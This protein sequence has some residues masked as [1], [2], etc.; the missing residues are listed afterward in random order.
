MTPAAPVLACFLCQQA[1]RHQLEFAVCASVQHQA[2]P[3]P[4]HLPWWLAGWPAVC[5][6]LAAVENHIKNQN[7]QLNS[8][9]GLPRLR[10]AVHDVRHIITGPGKGACRGG[11]AG[12]SV[13]VAGCSPTA[14]LLPS[15]ETRAQSHTATHT[16]HFATRAHVVVQTSN[17]E[18]QQHGADA[19]AK[20]QVIVWEEGAASHRER[21]VAT[22]AGE[23]RA[24]RAATPDSP[25][26]FA[27]PLLVE[28]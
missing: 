7:F 5:L 17:Q 14:L 6:P 9:E 25:L 10:G 26:T 11:K 1:A 19:H 24:C 22:Q 8:L 21:W 2:Q 3:P 16:R 27:L 15:P 12:S 28:A 18:G 13:L 23:R 20:T 4:T